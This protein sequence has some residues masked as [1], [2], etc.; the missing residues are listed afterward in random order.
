MPAPVVRSSIL[1]PAGTSFVTMLPASGPPVLS[2]DGTRLAFTARD[3]KSKVLLYVRPLR[4]LTARP[5]AGTD[6]AIYPFW[7]PDGR[8]IGFFAAG[9]LKK[10]NADGGPPQNLCDSVGG[11]GGAWS[12][13]GLIVFTPSSNQRLFSCLLYTSLTIERLYRVRYLHRGPHRRLSAVELCRLLWLNLAR[14]LAP[15]TS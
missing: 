15:N 10:I 1:P 8:E 4:S 9:K 13:Y 11:R 7:S 12:K 2:P 3:E 6:D 14:P 5:L